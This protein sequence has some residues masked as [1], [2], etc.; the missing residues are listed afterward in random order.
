[1]PK[2]AEDVD[3]GDAFFVGPTHDI[4]LCVIEGRE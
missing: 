3:W 4:V 1:M 2:E